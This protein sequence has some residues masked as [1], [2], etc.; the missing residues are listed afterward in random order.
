MELVMDSG[1]RL[2]RTLVGT[3]T[4]DKNEKTVV[5]VV[6][7]RFQHPVYGKY[8]QRRKKYMAHDPQNSCK[9]GDVILI[10]ENRPLSRRKRWLVKEILERAV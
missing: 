4:S 9:V 3:V 10:E 5:V 7:R 1:K 8:I 6:S 2:R